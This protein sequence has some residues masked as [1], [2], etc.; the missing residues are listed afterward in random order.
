MCIWTDL[1]L[2]DACLMACWQMI[3]NVNVKADKYDEHEEY[4]WMVKFGI[5]MGI[6]KIIKLHWKK[7]SLIHLFFTSN[8]TSHFVHLFI[9]CAFHLNIKNVWIPTWS[10]ISLPVKNWDLEWIMMMTVVTEVILFLWNYVHRS[11]MIFW[12]TTKCRHS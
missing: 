2:C 7:L 11:R 1:V 10:F 8:K 5:E 3:Y 9:T 6:I 4:Q 12:L